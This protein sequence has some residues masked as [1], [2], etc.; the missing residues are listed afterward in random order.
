MARRI[1]GA[2]AAARV[3]A[4]VAVVASTALAGAVPASADTVVDGLVLSPATVAPGGTA[5]ATATFTSTSAGSQVVH[6]DYQSTLVGGTWTS[7]SLAAAT[8][9]VGCGVSGAR[10][11]CTWTSSAA[12]EVATLTAVLALAPTASTGEYSIFAVGSSDYLARTL[13]VA[14]DVPAPAVSLSAPTV[15]P[16]GALTATSRYF[17]LTA[18]ALRT[19]LT[20]APS[21]GGAVFGVLTG[22]TGLSNCVVGGRSATCDWVSPSVGDTRSIVATVL[23]PPDATEGTV[24]R[25]IACGTVTGSVGTRCATGEARV[26]AAPVT[27]TTPVIPTSPLVVPQLSYPDGVGQEGRPIT[28][29]LPHV[30]GL[31]APIAYTVSRGALPAGLALDGATGAITGTPTVAGATTATITAR[32][33]SGRTASAPATI[34]VGAHQGDPHVDYPSGTGHAGSPM[35]ALVPHTSGLSGTITYGVK[36]G[37]LPPGLSLN[38]LTGVISGTPARPGV[39]EVTVR[40]SGIEGSASATVTIAVGGRRVQEPRRGVALALTAL[41]Q[42]GTTVLTPA[43]AVTTAGRQIRTQVTCSPVT[44]ARVPSVTPAGDAGPL[45]RILRGPGTRVAVT[46]L[47]GSVRVV[48]TYS[49]PGDDTY[50]PFVSRVVYVNGQPA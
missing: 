36:A 8:P 30:A 3:L 12:G 2:R 40:A 31:A 45:C 20:L 35:R 32:G 29:M 44:R 34:S 10:A 14:Y 7:V 1:A 28:P 42:P 39:T 9:G 18:P 41:N 5:T 47:N 6:L 46:V 27:P 11:E 16:G 43:R 50:Q 48:V 49:A 26:V 4:V 24:I 15:A 21:S 13:R 17:G 38:S 19:S 33:S 22:S 23:V 25:V 37:K